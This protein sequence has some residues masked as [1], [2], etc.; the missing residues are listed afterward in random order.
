MLTY[1]YAT[2]AK[3]TDDDTTEYVAEKVLENFCDNDTREIV[4]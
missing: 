3:Y 1:V 2:I 4:Q